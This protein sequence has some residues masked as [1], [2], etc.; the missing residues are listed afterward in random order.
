MFRC[1]AVKVGCVILWGQV[2]ELCEYD[3]GSSVIAISDRPMLPV[4]LSH[5]DK[6]VMVWHILFF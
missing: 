1:H 4:T 5:S 2:L 6:G 3:G